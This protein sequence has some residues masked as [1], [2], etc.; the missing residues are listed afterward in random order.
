MFNN[1]SI[2]T[3]LI[4]VTYNWVEALELLLLSLKN[5][6]IK[7]TELLISDDGSTEE[8][9]KLIDKFRTE[10]DFPIIHV[11]HEDNGFRK[12]VILNK[13]IKKCTGDYIIQIDGDCIMNRYFIEDHIKARRNSCFIHGSRVLL[14]E[15]FSKEVLSQKITEFPSYIAKSKNNMNAF[16]S[17]ILSSVY[18]SKSTSLKSTRGCNFS[19]WKED[20]LKVNGYNEAMIG[21][22]LEDTELSARLINLGCK[23]IKLKHLGLQYHI[24]HPEKSKEGFNVNEEILDKT[25]QNQVI[26]TP[27]GIYKQ[28]ELEKNNHLT[29]I[30]PTF[31]EEKNIKEA[32]ENLSFADEILIIDSF[33]TDK[34]I[35]IAK[36]FK[37]KILQR[38]F[39]NFSSQKNYA[40]S[41]A[42]NNWILMLDADER[43]TTKAINEIVRTLNKKN[44]ADAF[45]MHRQN[46][47]LGKKISFSG[48]QNDKVIKLFNRTKAKYNGK[49]VH[50]E[51]E[52]SGKTAFLKSK[53]LHYT[54][55]EKEDYK[56]KIE[57]YAKLKSEELFKQ[58]IKPIAY[59]FYFKP[60]YRFVYH[61][62]FKLGFLDG[63]SGFTIAKINAYGVKKRYDDLKKRYES[64]NQ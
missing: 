31:N 14:N 39:D 22:G 2:K 15:N 18:M 25:T 40:I 3:S 48:W 62:I 56:K 12:T 23:K 8:T 10:F 53:L 32:I 58:N 7:P 41:Q 57:L 20:M 59:H 60:V 5:Q 63:K 19:F 37:V 55:R 38:K 24:F 16:R 44:I 36:Q 13:T 34:T 28:K 6:T 51:I 64:S 35:E 17:P 47:F 46:Y 43:L 50:E 4:I 21:W 42:Q 49:L 29:A 30:I 52:C 1:S 61:Y 26:V 54:Y 9:K 45:W 27:N 33:S 11:W